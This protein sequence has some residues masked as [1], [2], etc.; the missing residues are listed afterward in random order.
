MYHSVLFLLTLLINFLCHSADFAYDFF[1]FPAHII[2]SFVARASKR[3]IKEKRKVGTAAPSS[4]KVGGL[5]APSPNFVQPEINIGMAQ[6]MNIPPSPDAGNMAGAAA[7]PQ[8]KGCCLAR[9]S[10]VRLIYS[11]L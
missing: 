1:S 4:K 2:A 3:N 7:G 11:A 9:W 8:P 6:K 5:S 10:F